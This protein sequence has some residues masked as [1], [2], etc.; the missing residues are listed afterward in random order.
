MPSRNHGL[1]QANLIFAFKRD[2]RFEVLSE[3]TLELGGHS[4]VPDVSVYPRRPVDWNN[5]VVRETEPPLAV[6][7]IF[8]PRQG[9]LDVM[10]HVAAYLEAGVKSVWVL[11]PPLRTI[12]I[13]HAQ[14][15]P[16]TFSEGKAADS[17]T[18]LEVEVGAVFS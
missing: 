11:V 18:G 9:Y 13:Y 15:P 5:D 3:L 6:A 14:E 10:E 1:A 2:G 7:E 17:A 4:L 16:K 8:S 12:T